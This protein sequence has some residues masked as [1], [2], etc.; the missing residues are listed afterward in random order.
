MG[1]GKKEISS[2]LNR[3]LRFHQDFLVYVHFIFY[4][5][6]EHT[7]HPC[8]LM[9]TEKANMDVCF[10]V[11]VNVCMSLSLSLDT[12]IKRYIDIYQN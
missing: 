1:L 10:C 7:S 4:T 6:A 8:H 9:L 12:D 2:I 3:N 5:K 11:C